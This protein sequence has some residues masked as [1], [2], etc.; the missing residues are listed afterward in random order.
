MLSFFQAFK[1][2]RQ[3]HVVLKPCCNGG[4]HP[5]VGWEAGSFVSPNSDFDC[6]LIGVFPRKCF[7]IDKAYIVRNHKNVCAYLRVKN[8]YVIYQPTSA[9]QGFR[10]GGDPGV[11]RWELWNFFRGGIDS[12][13]S[14]SQH[15]T[16]QVSNCFCDYSD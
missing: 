16:M 7:G 4:L 2:P 3:S 6:N 14:W 15:V 1:R 11:L 9:M 13:C 5:R 8:S 10:S 12:D